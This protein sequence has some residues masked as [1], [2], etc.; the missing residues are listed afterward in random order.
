MALFN[1]FKSKITNILKSSG[2]GLEKSELPWEKFY[3]AVG[4]LPVELL[5]YQVS[6]D[7]TALF[8]YL[9]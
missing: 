3:R 7:C 2:R 5:V 8:I 9:I 4:V 6:M 1:V